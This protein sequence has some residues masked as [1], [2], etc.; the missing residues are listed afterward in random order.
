M[1]RKILAVL[2]LFLFII[3]EISFLVSMADGSRD[4]VWGVIDTSLW[5]VWIVSTLGWFFKKVTLGPMRFVVGIFNL[6]I[7][8]Y[9][10]VLL[11]LTLINPENKLSEGLFSFFLCVLFAANMYAIFTQEEKVE[12]FSDL[13]CGYKTN[14]MVWLMRKILIVPDV[15]LF[16]LLGAAC[17]TVSMAGGNDQRLIGI[18]V[19]AFLVL[20]IVSTL[21]LFLKK[22][23]FGTVR[24][25]AGIFSLILALFCEYT[26]WTLLDNWTNI[27][28][29]WLYFL[30]FTVVFALNVYATCKREGKPEGKKLNEETAAVAER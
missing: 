20:W 23:R 10:V 8:L 27:R 13:L 9:W 2:D 14:G 24:F 4:L 18:C 6:L 17:W 15:L 5:A 3:V 28:S 30:F 16:I 12:L 22:I 19:I 26:S 25:I 11:F 29:G 7:A 21:G 1:L